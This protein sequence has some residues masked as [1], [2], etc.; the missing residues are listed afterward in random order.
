MPSRR[1]LVTII[2]GALLL[3]IGSLAYQHYWNR[4]MPGAL[5]DSIAV[6][7]ASRRADSLAHA[8]LVTR[9]ETIYVQSQ[10][11]TDS[12][13]SIASHAEIAHANAVAL[14][15]QARLAQTARDSA[16][17]WM[18]AYD[19]SQRRGDSL[20]AALL[21]ERRASES[22][23]LAALTYQRADSASQDRLAR[24]QRLNASLVGELQHASNG[25]RVLPFVRCLTRKESAVAGAALTY[26][27]LRKAT[28]A[29]LLP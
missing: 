8:Q 4:P 25:C 14:A 18:Q 15:A 10:A 16:R 3:V 26:I 9:A 17:F 28:G 20:D 11:R 5:R 12:S 27:A 6:V 19:E 7:T 24:V 2:A 29:S 21:V 13:R 1:P 23:R 22:A